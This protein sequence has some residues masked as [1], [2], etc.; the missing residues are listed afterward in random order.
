MLQW[1]LPD[2]IISAI[3]KAFSD[4]QNTLS[5]LPLWGPGYEVDGGTECLEGY[6][7]WGSDHSGS[8]ASC[9]SG[10]DGLSWPGNPAFTNKGL[11]I[12]HPLHFGFTEFVATPQ[13]AA[14]STTNCGC[15]FWP[16]AKFNY[17]NGCNIGPSSRKPASRGL[18]SAHS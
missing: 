1:T 10:T 15:F 2:R 16:K 9:C 6:M 13:C 17:S 8:I 4:P 18:C 12:S 5:I 14:S 3:Q 11:G 7:R